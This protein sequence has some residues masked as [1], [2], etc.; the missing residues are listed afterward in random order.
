MNS[1][2][3]CECNYYHVS[4][5]ANLVFIDA[6]PKRSA[7]THS[8]LTSATA[9]L[10]TQ[11]MD[12]GVRTLTNATMVRLRVART[13]FASTQREAI[14]ASVCPVSKAMVGPANAWG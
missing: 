5:V 9:L 2:C 13:P 3:T 14:L 11:A 6:A 7:I 8:V 4:S 1:D 10:D 12:S